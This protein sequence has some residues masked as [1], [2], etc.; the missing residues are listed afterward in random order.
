MILRAGPQRI[1]HRVLAGFSVLA[2]FLLCGSVA[3]AKPSEEELRGWI[4][5][6]KT[7][8]KGP[9]ER[10]RWFCK[11]GSVLPPKAYAC[12][13]HG[14]G[15]QHGERN[16]K[17]EALRA[18]GYFLANVLAQLEPGEF[19]GSQ[20]RL[21]AL[22]ELLLER[23]LIGWDDGWIFRG[24]RSYRGA[25][26]SEDEEAA[27]HALMLAMWADPRWREVERYP[28]LREAVRLLPLSP[29][30]NSASHVRQ[31]ALEV[32]NKD[33]GFQ[34]LRGKIHNLPDAGDAA[35]VRGYAKKS[36]KKKLGGDYE[37][38]AEAIDSLYTSGAAADTALQLA[39]QLEG[40]RLQGTMVQLATMM[41]TEREPV[42][43]IALAARLMGL[44]R[45][46]LPGIDDSELALSLLNLSLTLEAEIYTIGTEVLTGLDRMT[47]EERLEALDRGAEALYGA[48]FLTTRHLVGVKESLARLRDDANLSLPMYREELAYLARVAQWSSQTLEFY[49]AP[50][51]AKLAPLEPLVH[52]YS[53][54]RL[55]GSPLLTYSRVID[56]LVLD[57]NQLA[58]IEHELYGER[59]GAGLRALNPGLTRGVLYTN[60]PAGSKDVDLEG[61][62]VLPETTAD[63]PPVAGIL[64]RGE[65]SSL[66]H[67]QLLA[68]NLG[69][70]NVVV[71][72]DLL[73]VLEEKKGSASVLAVSPHGVV[74][75]VADGPRWDPIFGREAEEQVDF[76]I[77]PD[78]KKLDLSSAQVLPLSEL[79]ATDSGR[80]SGPKGAN[81][82]ELKHFFGDQ[83]PD[84]F[85]IPFGTFRKLLDQPIESGGPSV[86]NW[87]KAEYDELAKL[88]K[89]PEK[90]QK[91]A[92]AF[93]ERLRNWVL[94]A[95]PGPEFHRSLRSALEGQFGPDGS[96]GVFL[97]SDTNVEDL[98]GFTGAG[99]NLTVPNVVGYDNVFASIRD[100]WASPFSDRSFQWR[101]SHMTDPEYVFPAIVVQIG[102]D[103]QKSGVMVTADTESGA[104]GWL[105]VAVNEGVGGAVEGQ[106]AESLRI[107]RDTGEVRFLAQ[108]TTPER[109]QL[110]QQ[111]GIDH[112]PATGSERVLEEAEIAQLIELAKD[113]ARRFTTLR[114][115]SGNTMPADIE[116]A[117]RN[118]RLALLQIRPFVES[119]KA[120]SSSYLAEMDAG[121]RQSQG[122]RVSL[123]GV[124]A[125]G[126][127]GGE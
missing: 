103:S 85:V 66:S 120:Q 124:P 54:D 98:E 47:R 1:L 62:Y 81:L 116:F 61:I 79:R 63:L 109:V 108:A 45:K 95:D 68:R 46:Y 114:D 26:Q 104:E 40:S 9:F 30:E 41:Q 127:G 123:D 111:G 88:E 83:V 118:G 86:W 94:A 106:S 8:P 15:V 53:Q 70:P 21:E 110:N 69:I 20:A 56:S 65:G 60:D 87:M 2:L 28:L 52:L 71:R 80:R 33:S 48:G 18:E 92:A 107:N 84:G 50:P 125:S 6:F 91:R 42:M 101:Q 55:R 14:G 35:S 10:I 90:H 4:E 11:D 29:D 82:G 38:L 22:K 64:T 31:L 19:V 23:F 17:A 13:K 32:A 5:G 97:R 93:L 89:K 24:A 49:F 105:S 73:P 72:E 78:L 7:S 67:V 112:L 43:R 74:Q 57:A 36:G 126:A 16:E 117:F 102:Y 58:G 3:G 75:L 12:A 27:A 115:E 37:E 39:E 121:I 113:V 122:I 59:L 25:L 44:V 76:V 77:R 100:V 51:V 99:L 34:E 96:Y 119:S